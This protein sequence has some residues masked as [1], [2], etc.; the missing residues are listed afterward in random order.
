MEKAV[1]LTVGQRQKNKGMSWRP[2]GSRALSLLKVAELN[3][4]WQQLW[5]PALAA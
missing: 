1:D 4:Q 2:N 3:G 5:F